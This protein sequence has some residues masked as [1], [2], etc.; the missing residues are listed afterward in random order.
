MIVGVVIVVM[1]YVCCWAK[2][3]LE[4]ARRLT[5]NLELSALLVEQENVCLI[6]LEMHS[7]V[8]KLVQPNRAANQILLV[9]SANETPVFV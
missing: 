6:R 5:K 4:N 9:I 7:F 2:Q 8:K 1:I 3:S